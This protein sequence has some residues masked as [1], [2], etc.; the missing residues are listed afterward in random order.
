VTGEP[1]SYAPFAPNEPNGLGSEECVAIRAAGW[2]DEPCGYP[3]SGLL[4]PSPARNLPFVCETGCGN[5]VVEPGEECDPPAAGA[6]TATCKSVRACLEPGGYSSPVNGHC[7]FPQAVITDYQTALAACP[8]G[9]HLATL[10]SPAET[11]AGLQA[12]AEDCWIALSAPQGAPGFHWDVS[13]EDFNARR[14]HG[15]TNDDPNVL[16]AACG[17]LTPQ[18]TAGWR[19]RDCA[20]SSY[21]RLC[22]RE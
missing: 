12:V 6:C 3:S 16:N 8:N 18:A 14:Y 2:D 22:E 11:E 13:G 20:T 5:G 17:V 4:G 21:A 19:D 15:F 10:N 9:T 1:V 7:Y